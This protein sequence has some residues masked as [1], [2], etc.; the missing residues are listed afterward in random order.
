MYV[1]SLN[2]FFCHLQQK[3]FQLYKYHLGDTAEAT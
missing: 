3:E 1:P 2:C